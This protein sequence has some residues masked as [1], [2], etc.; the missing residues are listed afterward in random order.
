MNVEDSAG[1]TRAASVFFVSPG[2]VNFLI[3]QGTAN[4]M[5]TVT[6][7]SG[8]GTQTS[9]TVEVANIAPG[10]YTVNAAG[11]A[12]AFAIYAEPGGSQ[13]RVNVAEVDTSTNQIV[14]NPIAL[15]SQSSPV[16][17][18]LYGTGF[19]HAAMSQVTV[20]IGSVA[21]TP[22]YAGA[23]PSDAGLDQIDVPIP[24]SLKGSGDVAV[25]VTVAGQA[26]NTVRITIQ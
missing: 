4:G 9:G 3:P 17:L 12:A 16:Y 18:E 19:R 11:L 6:V 7:K 1:S 5:A 2:Q 14:P 13:K 24:Y 8:D 22:T 26:V 25:V 15:V 21:V 23:Q 10:L 20:T